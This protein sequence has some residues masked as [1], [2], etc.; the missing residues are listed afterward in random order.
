MAMRGQHKRGS[1]R[2][3]R[4]RIGRVAEHDRIGAF[5][6]A[7]ERSAKVGMTSPSIGNAGN[8]DLTTASAN[9]DVAIPERGDACVLQRGRDVGAIIPDVV[10]ADDGDDAIARANRRERCDAADDFLVLGWRALKR[11]LVAV[12]IIAEQ[13]NQLRPQRIDTLLQRY[14][15][16]GQI[17]IVK[18]VFFATNKDIILQQ[19]YPVLQSV[20]D[21]LKASPEIKKVSIEGHTDNRGT[22]EA[23]RDLSERR[24]RSVRKWLT[25]NGVDP[26]RLQSLGF[27]PWRPIDTNDTP[28]GREKNRRVE[29]VIIDP[30]QSG[31]VRSLDASQIEVPVSPDQSDSSPTPPPA[32][33][34]K[35]TGA[36]KGKGKGK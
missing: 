4:E 36:G 27:G 29:F 22:A 23:N 8:H 21:V 28:A 10:I 15:T 33:T 25:D 14:V 24:A 2:H 7:I 30:P 31:G 19:S 11:M 9:D 1:R 13:H 34:P 16:S 3:V 17:V 5:R 20:A 12:H 32:A 26:G 18:P 35:R 6:R